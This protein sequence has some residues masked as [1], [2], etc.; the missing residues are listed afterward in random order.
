MP[1]HCTD[2]MPRNRHIAV[3]GEQIIMG[4]VTINTLTAKVSYLKF[5][6]LEACG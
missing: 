1:R 3:I 6:Q 5:L 4:Y 2:R